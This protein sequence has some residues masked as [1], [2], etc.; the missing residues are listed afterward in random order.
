MSDDRRVRYAEGNHISFWCPG[1]DRAHTIDIGPGGWEWDEATLTVTPSIKVMY[2][3]WEPPVTPENL[4]EF[5]RQPWEQHPVDA[6]CHSFI[7]NGVWEFLGDCTH[8][9]VGQHVPLVD[10]P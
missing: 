1:C 6:V 8:A 10:W 9:L 4:D 2:R 7:R 5:K 3:R